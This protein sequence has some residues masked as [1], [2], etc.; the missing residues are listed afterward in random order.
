MFT[1]LYRAPTEGSQF[2]CLLQ[3][4]T[5]SPG[6]DEHFSMFFGQFGPFIWFVLST[7]RRKAVAM[8]A[9]DPVKFGA[10]LF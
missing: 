10:I 9:L 7:C 4:A 2:N 8:E 1:K 3:I 5:V 6:R